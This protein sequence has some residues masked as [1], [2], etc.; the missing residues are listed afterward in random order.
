VLT[1]GT[2]EPVLART[3]CPLSMTAMLPQLLGQL[4]HWIEHEH[5]NG[6]LRVDDPALLPDTAH[7]IPALTESLHDASRHLR[8]AAE[9]LDT[10]PPIHHPPRR[11]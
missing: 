7:T 1:A 10:A 8:R 5:R 11:R 9:A 3:V 4:G 6:R 2:H